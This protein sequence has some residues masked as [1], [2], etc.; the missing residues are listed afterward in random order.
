MEVLTKAEEQ[1]MHLL[2]N[3]GPSYVKDLVAA[4]PAPRP[5]YTTVSTIVRILEE[6][7][8]VKHE[9]H[10]RTHRYQARVSK[11]AY[12]SR[13]MKRLVRDYFEGSPKELLSFFLDR[14][15]L[16]AQEVDA[17]LKLIRSKRPS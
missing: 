5:A 3:L 2:W 17:L 11:E 9:A 12:G 15:K 4:M 14:E 13:S 1:V 7:G 6:K 8:F 16:D 10:G